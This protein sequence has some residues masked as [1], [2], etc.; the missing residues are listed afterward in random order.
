MTKNMFFGALTFI[1]F[2]IIAGTAGA[3]DL[4]PF[5]SLTQITIQ[6]LIGLGV[7]VMGALHLEYN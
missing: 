5:M 4:N 7:M 6:T 3:S 2:L 1:G